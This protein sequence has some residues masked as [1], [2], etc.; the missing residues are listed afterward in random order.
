MKTANLL[1]NLAFGDKDPRAEPLH[2][3][4]QGRVLLFT[5]KAGQAIRE[6]NAPSS[7]FF[8]VVLKGQGVFSGGDGV[9][10]TCGPNTLLVFDAGEQHAVRAVDELVFV[11]FLHGAPGA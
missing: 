3:D 1:E 5:L 11:G 4:E 9:E 6:H 8:V 7:P 2:F 10:H